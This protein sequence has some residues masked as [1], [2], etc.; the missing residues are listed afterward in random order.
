MSARRLRVDLKCR[1]HLLARGGELPGEE[2]HRRQALMGERGIRSQRRRLPGLLQR[3]LQA[4]LRQ[5]HDGKLSVGL[6]CPGVE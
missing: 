6:V 1:L 3:R 2:M 5:F 4:T